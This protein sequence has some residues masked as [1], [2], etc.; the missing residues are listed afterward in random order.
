MERAVK[1]VTSCMVA[2]TQIQHATEAI[3]DE[4]LEMPLVFSPQ[5][6]CFA[7]VEQC[8]SDEGCSV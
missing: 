6:P 4:D 5:W 8:C 2:E 3:V 1:C 7:N